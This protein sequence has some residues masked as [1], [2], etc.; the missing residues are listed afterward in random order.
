[1]PMILDLSA[2]NILYQQEGRFSGA[3]AWCKSYLPEIQ[4]CVNL[5]ASQ[6]G[7]VPCS[8]QV[9]FHPLRHL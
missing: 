6:V 2:N 7:L 3:G 8:R 9:W 5:F 4:I 1:M